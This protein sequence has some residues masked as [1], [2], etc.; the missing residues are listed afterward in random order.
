LSL[1]VIFLPVSFMSSISGRFLYQFGITASVAIMVS[2]FVSFSLTPMMSARMLAKEAN[3]ASAHA[4]SRGGFYA[5]I[6]RFYTRL[7][8][9][10][11]GHRAAVVVVGLLVIA[12]A[13]PLYG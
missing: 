12:S 5:H 8:R 1:V 2:L 13:V 11:M 3:D 10:A 4:A 6:D 9:F 7:L